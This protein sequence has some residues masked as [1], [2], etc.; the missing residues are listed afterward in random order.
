MSRSIL[1]AALLP[2][3]AVAT[4]TTVAHQG[5]ML[6]ANGEPLQGEETVTVSIVDDADVGEGNAVA[7]VTTSVQFDDG[8]FSVVIPGV[9]SSDLD[10]DRW[11]SVVVDGTELGP[12]QAVHATPFATVSASADQAQAVSCA[13]GFVRVA[14]GDA[15]ICIMVDPISEAGCWGEECPSAGYRNCSCTEL[16]VAIRNG[17]VNPTSD[18]INPAGEYCEVGLGH[19]ASPDPS[20]GCASGAPPSI[21]K[22]YPNPDPN[23]LPVNFYNVRGAIGVAVCD[24]SR[25]SA[26]TGSPYGSYRCCY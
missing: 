14:G 8:Y 3:V 1:L 10:G 19:C 21:G 16:R 22:I 17:V 12:R 2:A 24:Q 6:D 20:G 23:N 18:A 11:L 4:P 15:G 5:R 26:H 9:E 7:T 25:P 13:P